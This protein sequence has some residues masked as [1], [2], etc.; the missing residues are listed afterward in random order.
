MQPALLVESSVRACALPA[1]PAVDRPGAELS[2][3]A[4]RRNVQRSDIVRMTAGFAPALRGLNGL[5]FI[6][7]WHQRC[8]GA[9]GEPQRWPASF[10]L[11]DDL[12]DDGLVA[13]HIRS[14]ET[15]PALPP[16]IASQATLGKDRHRVR[17]CTTTPIERTLT[18]PDLRARRHRRSTGQTI[19]RGAPVVSVTASGSSVRE[20]ETRARR[21]GPRQCAAWLRRA[22]LVCMVVRRVCCRHEVHERRDAP[23]SRP[24][25]PIRP[26]PGEQQPCAMTRRRHS[27][28]QCS[29]P[30]RWWRKARCTR[31]PMCTG[32]AVEPDACGR[33]P[34]SSMPASNVHRAVV[35]DGAPRGQI[36][37]WVAWAVCAC[38]VR[39][40][41]AT[42]KPCGSDLAGQVQVSAA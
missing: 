16:G 39:C 12:A 30:A 42:T 33:A 22:D 7:R 5:D 36:S 29:G 19:P 17:G 2:D 25:H 6:A 34:G 9:G 26:F 14:F 31:R 32:V 23:S 35:E 38:A 15:L 24:Y 40:S 10:E 28:C 13:A 37:A 8:A 41:W 11:Y 21:R 1:T 4:L 27:A 3:P 18:F 20:V